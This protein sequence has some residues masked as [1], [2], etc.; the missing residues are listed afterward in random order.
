MYP[1]FRHHVTTRSAV[2]SPLEITLVC[3]YDSVTNQGTVDAT[4]TNTSASAVAGNIHFVVIED[5][6]PYNWGGGMTELNHLMRDML[7]DATGEAVTVPVADTIIRSRNFSIGTTWNEMNCKVVAFVQAAN[8][9]IFQGA[10]IAVVPEPYMVYYG[11]TVAELAGNG[12]GYGEPGEDIE[13]RAFGKN[14]GAGTYTDPV[15][16]D[17]SD[18]YISIMTPYAYGFSIGP[19]DVDTVSGWTFN[20]SSGCP[21]PHLAEFQLIFTNGD[22]SIV[23][24]LV[25]TRSGLSDDIESGEGD[26]THS[27]IYDN[28]HITEH[29]SISPTHSWYCGVENLWHYTNQ[30]DA[31]LVSTYFVVSPD[32]A[33]NFYHYYSLEPG[34]DYSYVEIDDGSGWWYTLDEYNGNQLTWTQSSY[35][36]SEYNGQT[37]RVRFRFVS[38]YSTYAEGW[39]IDDVLV[40]MLGIQELNTPQDLSTISLN[41]HPNPFQHSTEIRYSIFDTRYSMQKP[42]IRIYDA[43]GRLVK[44]LN[45][46]SRI[47][48]QESAI[49]WHGDD[50]AGR[51]LPG[52]VYFVTLTTPDRELVEKAILLR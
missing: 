1:F 12:N 9:Q 26:W 31:S 35:A 52:G 47:E 10:E 32:S 48:N 25:A 45:P 51:K 42:T 3:N 43:T 23:P 36:L 33:L 30:N 14:I 41:V 27:G 7:P 46:E 6:I 28:W 22:T 18:P 20:I 34:W 15:M 17:C 44:S 37:V 40:P 8:R 11:M 39:Y 24:F 4:V 50:N 49:S 21:D 16:V 38:D 2:E 29:N 19:G 5:H 13:V